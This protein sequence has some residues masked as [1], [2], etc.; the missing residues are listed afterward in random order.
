MGLLAGPA[1]LHGLSLFVP[2]VVAGPPSASFDSGSMEDWR[3]RP[4][5]PTEIHVFLF[6]V[7]VFTTVLT[8]CFEYFFTFL[9]LA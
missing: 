7:I 6:I 1:G 2:G 4:S 9:P 3:E 8:S 5:R